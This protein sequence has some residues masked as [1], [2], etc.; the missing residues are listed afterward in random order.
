MFQSSGDYYFSVIRSG[1]DFLFI[2]IK[3]EPLST[4][5]HIPGRR[6]I[7]ALQGVGAG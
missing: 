2:K 6:R 7:V 5:W 4:H 3:L 1:I